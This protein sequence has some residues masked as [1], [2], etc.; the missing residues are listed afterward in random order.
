M[1]FYTYICTL[2]NIQLSV[3]IQIISNPLHG[4][5]KCM[6]VSVFILFTLKLSLFDLLIQLFPT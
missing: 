6:C 5:I 2:C 1:N 3:Y 4:I